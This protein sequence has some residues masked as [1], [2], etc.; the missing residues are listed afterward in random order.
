MP[1]A[2]PGGGRP[3]SK[4]YANVTATGADGVEYVAFPAE[5]EG[6]YPADGR[7]RQNVTNIL[8]NDALE[9][10][11]IR[12]SFGEFAG[13]A[14]GVPLDLRLRLVDID[15][16][17]AP[18]AGHAIYVWHCDAKGEYSL[19]SLPEQNYL[20]GLQVADA[21][22]RVAFKTVL[23]ACYMGRFPHIH[24]ELFTDASAA[25]GGNAAIL[26][27]QL[28]VPQ[29][30]D[31][32]VYSTVPLY[33]GSTENLNR[34]TLE[35]DNVFGDN[36]AKQVKAQTLILSGSPETGYIADAVIGYTSQYGA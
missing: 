16:G 21:D 32:A 19:Y 33:E 10:S 20:R 26:T 24:F 36:T 22:G 27:S 14:K 11:D 8:G 17:A 18:L 35:N 6:P 25:T 3:I 2:P 1:P 28:A 15:N 9:R 12:S 13:T 7:G 5:T 4:T 29:E 23:P 34:V 30:Q 31:I